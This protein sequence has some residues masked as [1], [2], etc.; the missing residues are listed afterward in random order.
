MKSKLF[1]V[2]IPL[3]VTAVECHAAGAEKIVYIYADNCIWAATPIKQDILL[4]DSETGERRLLSVSMANVTVQDALRYICLGGGVDCRLE[5]DRIVI[6]EPSNEFPAW[7]FQIFTVSPAFAPMVGREV[8]DATVKAYFESLG[9]RLSCRQFKL[10]YQPDRRLLFI[11]HGAEEM[12]QIE[13]T[14]RLLGVFEG[15]AFDHDA[16]PP[17]PP[18]TVSYQRQLDLVLPLL[19]VEN[20]PVRKLL[21]LLADKARTTDPQHRGIPLVFLE[22]RP[23]DFARLTPEDWWRYSEVCGD[24]EGNTALPPAVKSDDPGE[25]APASQSP[26][27]R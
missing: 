20:I 9:I 18:K 1:W 12:A 16:S 13:K 21:L 25:L 17:P 7:Q 24:P 14:L 3:L 10:H 23:P 8:T 19:E 11:R 5:S 22:I 27:P 4:P 2:L 26:A 6:A 15:K